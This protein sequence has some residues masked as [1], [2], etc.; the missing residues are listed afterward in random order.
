MQDVV[1]CLWGRAGID[2]AAQGLLGAGGRL[3]ESLGGKSRAVI[4]GPA[5]DALIAA[6]QAAADTVVVVEDELLGEYHPENF[7]TALVSVCKRFSPRAVLLGND[8][9][10]QELAPRL[11]HRLG[12]SAAGDAVDVKVADGRMLVTRGVYGGKA[13]AVIALPRSPASCVGPRSGD[14]ARRGSR[15]RAKSSG[16]DWDWCPMLASRSYRATSKPRRERDWKMPG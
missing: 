6:A 7:L 15:R 4:L 2:R 1:I 8:S 9:A 3:A 11:A 13:T 12:G 14:G 5:D 16:F 10:G